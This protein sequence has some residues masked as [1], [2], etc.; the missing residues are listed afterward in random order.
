M[1]QFVVQETSG[2]ALLRPLHIIPRLKTRYCVSTSTSIYFANVTV[3][4]LRSE[5]LV[6]PARSAWKC[7]ESEFFCCLIW[8]PYHVGF[9]F[10]SLASQFNDVISPLQEPDKD[11]SA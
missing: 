8:V 6:G 4:R 11:P 7:L 2:I 3:K 9:L 1:Y 5:L 10:P